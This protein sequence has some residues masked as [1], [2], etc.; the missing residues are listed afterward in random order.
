MI[1][2]FLSGFSNYIPALLILLLLE[3]ASAADFGSWGPDWVVMR[4]PVLYTATCN[5][6]TTDLTTYTHTVTITG[7]DDNARVTV[8]V[9]IVAE[10]SATDYTV[11]SV[12]VDSNAT[13]NYR[14]QGNNT[15]A[16][17]FFST[18]SEITG[19]ASVDVAVTYSEAITSSVVCVWALE[20]L[21]DNRPAYVADTGNNGAGNL[22]ALANNATT[23]DGFVLGVC[24][25]ATNSGVTFTWVGPT[26]VEDTGNGEFEYS[27]A[28]SAVTGDEA[29][30]SMSCDPTGTGNVAA[31]AAVYGNQGYG[32]AL[33]FAT[34]TCAS[35]DT[36]LTQYTFSG[37]SLGIGDERAVD[38]IVGVLGEDGATVFGVSTLTIEGSSNVT[39]VVDQGGAGVVNAAIWRTNAPITNADSVDVV[40]DFTEAIQAAAV[41]VWALQA[42]GARP[43]KTIGFRS[44]DDT[45]SGIINMQLDG[46]TPNGGF[47]VGVCAAAGTGSRA[48]WN[49]ITEQQDTDTTEFAFT[50]AQM[51]T[52]G[53]GMSVN[54]T[55]NANR[56]NC[57]YAGTADAVG[58]VASFR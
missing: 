51:Q 57:D 6:L 12:T 42:S 47:A 23:R 21:E 48:T 8:V 38:I 30:L 9:G 40:V 17:A 19:A 10:D 34:A 32:P 29:A 20:N 39:E 31:A 4:R 2:R 15:M 53:G 22:M 52:T 36:N 25:D 58:A 50:N 43:V 27:N 16:S 26:E 11:S 1:I 56:V 54:D 55:T 35:N 49:V 45:S 5:S 44:G 18:T 33:G 13:S 24:A 41:C 28:W 37:I 46:G 14:M 3:A 7:L